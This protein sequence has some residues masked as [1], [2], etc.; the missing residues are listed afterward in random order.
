MDKT[1]RDTAATNFLLEAWKVEKQ[2][3]MA[4]DQM[5]QQQSDR[6]FQ[7][8]QKAADQQFEREQQ[9]REHQNQAMQAAADAQTEQTSN[10][11]QQ[12]AQSIDALVKQVAELK[13]SVA[14]LASTPASSQPMHFNLGGGRKSVNM[15][16]IKDLKG[17]AIGMRGV[18]EPDE[19]GT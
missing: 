2:S 7:A 11:S 5:L 14:S 16:L 3:G 19:Q 13:Q 15:E 10:Q 9:G 4:S 1:K 8:Y 18:T 6:Q 12:F 17:N